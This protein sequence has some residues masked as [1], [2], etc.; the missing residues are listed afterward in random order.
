MTCG[1]SKAR[2]T[3]ECWRSGGGWLT[4]AKSGFLSGSEQSSPRGCRLT[5]RLSGGRPESWLLSVGGVT[6]QT[7][8]IG[9]LLG[10][11]GCQRIL[12]KGGTKGRGLTGPEE[13]PGSRLTSVGPEAP[14]GG[15]EGRSRRDLRLT[16]SCGLVLSEPA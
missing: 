12:S 11:V 15:P 7:N 14:R 13:T 5:K 8:L 2:R 4:E 1:G 10:L 9:L 3:S 6:E 16:E